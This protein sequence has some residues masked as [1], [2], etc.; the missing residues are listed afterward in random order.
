MG[1]RASS[2]EIGHGFLTAMCDF[3][4]GKQ[5]LKLRD[6]TGGKIPPPDIHIINPPER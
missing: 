3:Y 5:V 1:D 6:I 4:A 2:I